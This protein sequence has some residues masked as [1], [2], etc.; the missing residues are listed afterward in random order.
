MHK[1][2]FNLI[3]F[4]IITSLLFLFGYSSLEITETIT[5]TINWKSGKFTITFYSKIIAI[6]T[7]ICIVIY[8]VLKKKYFSK[9][10]KIIITSQ[11]K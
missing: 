3:F 10:K 1:A 11:K 9:N 8:F 2:S 7:V 6:I 4:L 5:E